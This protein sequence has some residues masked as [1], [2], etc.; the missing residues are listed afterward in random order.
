VREYLWLDNTP[1]A[2]IRTRYRNNG[3]VKDVQ[4]VYLHS[5]HLN[6]PRLATDAQQKVVWHWRGDAF[7]QG[8]A[9]RDPDGD[10]S[11]VN[12]RLRFPGQYRDAESGLHNNYFRDYDPNTGRYIESD[13]IGLDGGL[14][15]YAYVD[16]HPIAFTDPLGL[17]KFSIG[18]NASFQ[19][20]AAGASMSGSAGIDSTGNVCFEFQV[21]GRVGPGISV[22]ATF[23]GTIAQGTFCEGNSM[24]GGFFGEG[25]IGP[26]GGTGLAV[27]ADGLSSTFSA[28]GGIGGGA[29]GGSQVCITRTACPFR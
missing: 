21:C 7:G 20:T 29:A 11:K 12:V 28:K 9:D 15:T 24:S 6:T 5:D 25:G 4:K 14:N 8:R 23:E 27:G 1:L 26:F 18:A 2:Q 22:G 10:G 19:N 3:K 16:N 17:T 13:P